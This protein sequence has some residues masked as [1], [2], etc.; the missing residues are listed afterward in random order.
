LPELAEREVGTP[1]HQEHPEGLPVHL[2]D[3]QPGVLRVEPLLE[4]HDVP[5]RVRFA[6]RIEAEDEEGPWRI[7]SRIRKN[8]NGETH[9]GRRRTCFTDKRPAKVKTWAM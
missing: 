4:V 2:V 9:P 5:L 8:K 1:R 7:I 6:R 3:A